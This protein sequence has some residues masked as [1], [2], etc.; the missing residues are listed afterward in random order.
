M[1]SA[2]HPTPQVTVERETP[3]RLFQCGS[4]IPGWAGFCPTPGGALHSGSTGLVGMARNPRA[5][6][7]VCVSEYV[8][9]REWGLG[10]LSRA[11]MSQRSE[12]SQ[13]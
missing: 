6:V 1:S 13:W 3:N 12:V 9:E 4:P 8:R 5:R 10:Y 11:A 7:P 2:P